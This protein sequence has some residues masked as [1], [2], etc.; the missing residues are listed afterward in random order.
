MMQRQHM[1]RIAR[2]LL[3]AVLTAIPAFIIGIVYMSLVPG[4]NSG[5]M[6]LEQPIWVGQVSRMEWALF[7]M[8]TPVYFFAADL[9]HRRMLSELVVLWWPG[10]KTPILRR[11]YRF[12]SMDMLMS[13]GTTVAYFSSIAIL[14]IN[15]TQPADGLR[16]VLVRQSQRFVERQSGSHLGDHA[17]RCD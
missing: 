14:G 3:L 9:F 10:S 13:L 6:Y 1:W 5:V 12:G 11:F 4:D 2:R 17:A 8:A 15:A 16:D 7:I